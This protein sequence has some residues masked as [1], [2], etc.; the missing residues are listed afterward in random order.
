MV[1]MAEGNVRVKGVYGAISNSPNVNPLT[2]PDNLGRVHLTIV[3]GGTAY[4]DGNILKGDGY[5]DAGNAPHIEGASTCAIL[6]KDYVTVNTTMFMAAENQGPSW[7]PVLTNT[8]LQYIGIP[9]DA[10]AYDPI[11][12]FGFDP[13][14][15]TINGARSPVFLMMRHASNTDNAPAADRPAMNL[16][17]NSALSVGPAPA[18]PTHRSIDLTVN[19]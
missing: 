10:P 4:I 12:S 2:N 16:E 13:T 1:I 11:M 14:K 19:R 15:Y 3:S 6:A 5:L 18:F 9:T 17:I 8:D 7:T